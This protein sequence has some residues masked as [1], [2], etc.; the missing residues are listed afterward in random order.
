MEARVKLASLR[1]TE[2]GAGA[3]FSGHSRN[4]VASPPMVRMS[5]PHSGQVSSGLSKLHSAIL[6]ECYGASCRGKITTE[7]TAI[8]HPR[9]VLR[10]EVVAVD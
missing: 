3:V 7:K 1:G 4:Q 10:D 2:G 9:N 8:A 6:V 5:N